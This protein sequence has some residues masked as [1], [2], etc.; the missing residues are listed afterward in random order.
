MMIKLIGNLL[1][2]IVDLFYVL[3]RKLYNNTFFVV[4]RG[5]SDEPVPQ[6][7]SKVN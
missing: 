2:T 4:I 3:T 7:L 5:L 6:E 1:L